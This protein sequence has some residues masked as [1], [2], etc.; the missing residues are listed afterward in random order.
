MSGWG[1]VS[2]KPSN[3]PGVATRRSKMHLLLSPR[4]SGLISCPNQSIPSFTEFPVVQGL[5]LG[6]Y[7]IHTRRINWD[8]ATMLVH[9]LSASAAPLCLPGR[10]DNYSRLR[11]DL[12]RLAGV[13][14]RD[15]AQ[16]HKLKAVKYDPRQAS[17]AE[18]DK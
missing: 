15:P 9:I 17:R 8:H 10:T 7:S 18:V 16:F 14:E 5:F 3:H 4:W 1:R 13:E 12:R 2:E 6:T 11:D